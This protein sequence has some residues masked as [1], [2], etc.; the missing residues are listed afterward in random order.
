MI[1]F[2]IVIPHSILIT[3]SP[4][5]LLTNYVLGDT[6]LSRLTDDANLGL[7]HVNLHVSED[8][9]DMYSTYC[10]TAEYSDPELELLRKLML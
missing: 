8:C 2:D 3:M 6:R 4:R 9:L 7:C 10:I 1:R 5:E